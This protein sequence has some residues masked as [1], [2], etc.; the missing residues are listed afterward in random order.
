MWTYVEIKLSNV[1]VQGGDETGIS[2]DPF[3]LENYEFYVYVWLET[4][5]TGAEY[6][7]D[8]YIDGFDLYEGSRL[9]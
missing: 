4:V 1:K 5:P 3:E 6:A 8:F 2:T 9:A 7:F